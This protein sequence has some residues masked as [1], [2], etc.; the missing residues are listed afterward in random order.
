[1]A[2]KSFHFMHRCDRNVTGHLLFFFYEF[3]LLYDCLHDCADL[4]GRPDN[5][6]TAQCSN[7][8]AIDCT[9]PQPPK[10]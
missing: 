7:I 10:M 6:R 5:S 3:E 8:H 2:K 4:V 9:V 1:M